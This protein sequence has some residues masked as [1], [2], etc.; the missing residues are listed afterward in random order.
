M[1]KVLRIKVE[2]GD[3]F[4][5]DSLSGKKI[6]DLAR[7]SFGG[8]RLAVIQDK[9]VLHCILSA[10]E[11]IG[12][13]CS[14]ETA[15]IGPQ[16]KGG[17]EHSRAMRICRQGRQREKKTQADKCRLDGI[18]LLLGLLPWK[19]RRSENGLDLFEMPVFMDPDEREPLAKCQ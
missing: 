2:N 11:F 13:G 5:I 18:V 8:A 16:R 6:S 4:R 17:D 1:S 14:L 9:S 7:E 19:C 12:E 15:A 10:K 3:D